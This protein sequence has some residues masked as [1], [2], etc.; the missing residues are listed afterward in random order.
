MD[1]R[2]TI[3]I[4]MDHLLILYLWYYIITIIS[5]D[6]EN[7]FC[8]QRTIFCLYIVILIKSINSCSYPFLNSFNI[9]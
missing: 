4:D 7:F 8:N 1:D 2:K 6:L 9:I 3:L 5:I